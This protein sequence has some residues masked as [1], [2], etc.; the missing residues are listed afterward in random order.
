MAKELWRAWTEFFEA[1][2]SRELP[3]LDL[4]TD[5]TEIPSSVAE[6]LAVFQLGESGGG[7]VIDQARTSALFCAGP[8]Y[9]EAVRLFV[10]EEHRH[11][12]LLAMCV[13]MLGGTLK[14]SNWTARLFV[15]GRR[16]MGLRLKILVLLV[17]EVVGI[18]FYRAI[19]ARLQSSPL[20]SWL[21]EIVDDER[22]HLEFHCAFL[23]RQANTAWKRRVFVFAWRSIL[24][25]AAIVVMIDH[26]RTI[27]DLD[28]GFR[29]TWERWMAIGELAENLVTGQAAPIL[30]PEESF[31]R[32]A[33]ADSHA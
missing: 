5:Y 23:R 6:S 29:T 11:A 18:C 20:Q 17:A 13:R 3:A 12:N 16:L 2:Q 8:G 15:A 27:V 33:W 25:A 31:D 24:H 7:T 28:L 19:A 22:A 10:A 14:S 32:G 26:R 9:A 21:L 1:R 30:G 4:H